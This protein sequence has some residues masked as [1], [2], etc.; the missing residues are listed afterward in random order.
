MKNKDKISKERK[1]MPLEFT[2]RIPFK[3]DGVLHNISGTTYHG[4]KS[5]RNFLPAKKPKIEDKT[6]FKVHEK[7]LITSKYYEQKISVIIPIYYTTDP[8]LKQIKSILSQEYSNYEIIVV[9]DNPKKKLNIKKQIKPEEKKKIITINH[10]SQKGRSTAR[11]TGA[12]NAKGK[13]LLFMDSE[14]TL[15]D[16]KILEKLNKFYLIE[17]NRQIIAK[18]RVYYNTFFHELDQEKHGYMNNPLHFISNFFACTKI[19]YHKYLFDEK[20]GTRWGFEDH[21][22]ALGQI[23]SEAIILNNNHINAYSTDKSFD[24]LNIIKKWLECGINF[25][26]FVNKWGLEKVLEYDDLWNNRENKWMLKHDE[27]D[28]IKIM[29]KKIQILHS[30]I[31][32]RRSL[33]YIS[34]D[35]SEKQCELAKDVERIA[36]TYSYKYCF[37]QKDINEF[38]DIVKNYLKR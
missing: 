29:I 17:K 12:Q 10:T 16:S 24:L 28:I 33:S 14:L 36:K 1:K 35:Y 5:I 21:D 26:Y 27:K 11:N 38:V 13:I 23:N 8:I 19:Q 3:R 6:L 15:N 9:N 32:F 25:R 4:I 22:F 18:F 31:K 7:Y 37:T 20:Y 2:I 34:F 30:M